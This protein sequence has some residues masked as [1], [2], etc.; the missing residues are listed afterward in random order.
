MSAQKA[1]TINDVRADG[2]VVLTPSGFTEPRTYN[3]HRSHFNKVTWIKIGSYLGVQWH[4]VPMHK[5]LGEIKALVLAKFSGTPFTH[6]KP[7]PTVTVTHTPTHTPKEPIMDTSV[8][9][10]L[11]I[12]M[13]TLG[14]GVSEDKVREIVAR[15][16]L[17]IGKALADLSEQVRN[18]SPTQLV[19]NGVS[20][21]PTTGV[22]HRKYAKVAAA[23]SLRDN[24]Y[25]VGPAGTG[26]TTLPEQIA[27][28][29]GFRFVAMS[30]GVTD[31]KHD[32]AGYNDGNGRYNPTIFRD[33]WQNGGVVL[34]DEFDNCSPEL[35]I[36]LNAALANGY[37]TFPDGERVRKHADTIVCVAA[38]TYGTGATAQYVGRSPI[39]AATLDRFSFIEIELD[40]AVE[41][42]MVASVACDASLAKQWVQVVRAARKNVE[43]HGLRVMVTPRATVGGLKLLATGAFTMQEAFAARVAKGLDT[44]QLEKVAA[45]I[46]FG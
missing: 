3:L 40:E 23:M 13:E 9:K 30:C 27:E 2:T 33:Y 5:E 25:L 1:P 39:D 8:E 10:A 35:P 15:E 11:K 31:A 44:Q 43:K 14:A 37:F 7:E 36:V 20:L 26:K 38:N 16:T 12:L 28:A 21:K 46:T 42:A 19:I 18:T 29:M 45:G 24:V 22:V 32:Y 17:P 6:S 4:G 41:D 34:L